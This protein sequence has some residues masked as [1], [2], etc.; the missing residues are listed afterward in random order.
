MRSSSSRP[1]RP[2]LYA[3]EKPRFQ[4][5]SISLPDELWRWLEEQQKRWQD[6]SLSATVKR[7]IVEYEEKASQPP[8]HGLEAQK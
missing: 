8:S 6:S 2:P 7:I 4:G 3:A 1:G 5:R